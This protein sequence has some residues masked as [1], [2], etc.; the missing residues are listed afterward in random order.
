[1]SLALLL[2]TA[3]INLPT[4]A[5]DVIFWKVNKCNRKMLPTINYHL[6]YIFP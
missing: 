4:C 1:M 3:A 5:S 2:T 6:I